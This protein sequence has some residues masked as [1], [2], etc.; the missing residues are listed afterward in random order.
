MMLLG[1]AGV[2]GGGDFVK[3]YRGMLMHENT[4]G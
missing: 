1:L 2:Q 3:V 4:S